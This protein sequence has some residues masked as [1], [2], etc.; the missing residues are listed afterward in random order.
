MPSDQPYY[1]DYLPP[2]LVAKLVGGLLSTLVA[3]EVAKNAPMLGMSVGV[4]VAA[5]LFQ[6]NSK[7]LS[8]P[9]TTM[10]ARDSQCLVFTSNEEGGPS[11]NL[12]RAPAV[13]GCA[14]Y[15]AK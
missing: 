3:T 6:W 4:G 13:G 1:D 7:G 12:V 10:E 15:K 14:A 11:L 5:A 9:Y 2:K 8:T